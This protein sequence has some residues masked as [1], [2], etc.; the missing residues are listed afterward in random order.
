MKQSIISVKG[1]KKDT[2][3]QKEETFSYL[4]ANSNRIENYL[5][6]TSGDD[7]SP[8]KDLSHEF[9]PITQRQFQVDESSPKKVLSI[10][11]S[12]PASPK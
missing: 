5:A 4:K 8:K 12:S 10:Y 7:Q 11:E 9:R 2:T 6:S 1:I 3:P